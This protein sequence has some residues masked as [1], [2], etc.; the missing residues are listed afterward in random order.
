MSGK[1]GKDTHLGSEAGNLLSY[2]L[3][4]ID[5]NKN[6]LKI[7]SSLGTYKKTLKTR[8]GVR[9]AWFFFAYLS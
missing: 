7:V 6:F 8:R 3:Y 2:M 1:A 4:W 9:H 5:Q